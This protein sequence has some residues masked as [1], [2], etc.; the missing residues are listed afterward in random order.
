MGRKPRL[1]YEGAIYHV[2][3]RGNNKEYVF[4]HDDEKD[5]LI[6]NLEQGKRSMGFCLFGYVVMGNHY[7]LLLQTREYPLSKIMH[8]LNSDFGRYYNFK[9][10]RSGHVFQGRY[11][12][13]PVRGE[14]YLL[15]VLRYIHR[16]PVAAGLCP[17][18]ADYPYS[19]DTHYRECRNGLVDFEMVLGYLAEDLA[20]A[21]DKYREFMAG[22]DD[23]DYDA[24]EVIGDQVYSLPLTPMVRAPERKEL[25]EILAGTGVSLDDYKLIKAGSRMRHLTPYKKLYVETALRQMYTFQEIAGNIGLSDVAAIRMVRRGQARR[26]SLLSE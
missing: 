25:D 22:E 24:P 10:K 20:A 16:N 19:S 3:Q 9:Y 11:R 15:A 4:E 23:V 2:I 13:I 6:N 18:P 21:L 14:R 8:R 1:E 26:T 12:A 17:A 7:H 5:Y